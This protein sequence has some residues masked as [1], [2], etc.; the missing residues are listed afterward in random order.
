MKKYYEEQFKTCIFFARITYYPMTK[1]SDDELGDRLLYKVIELEEK[2]P[3]IIPSLCCSPLRKINK[4][5]EFLMRKL[6]SISWIFRIPFINHTYSN[7]PKKYYQKWCEIFDGYF[8]LEEIKKIDND[9]VQ[10]GGRD[11]IGE[12]VWTLIKEQEKYIP[13]LSEIKWIYNNHKYGRFFVD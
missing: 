4:L 6:P 3:L 10:K 11:F 2:Y 8:T 9:E 12:D 5:S 1:D 7:N 13:I